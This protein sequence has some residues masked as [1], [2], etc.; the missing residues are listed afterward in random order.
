MRTPITVI[1]HAFPAFICPLQSHAPHTP[2]LP[3]L[4]CLLP[5]RLLCRS[6]GQNSNSAMGT[7]EQSQARA[8]CC[9][10]LPCC[11]G[12]MSLQVGV[13]LVLTLSV[14][15]S[16]ASLVAGAQNELNG[17]D[18]QC[19]EKTSGAVLLADDVYVCGGTIQTLLPASEVSFPALCSCNVGYPHV[20]THTRLVRATLSV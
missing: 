16:A 15:I 20:R 5:S 17:C 13:V 9:A 4:A 12:G 2:S 11:A 7:S 1:M 6:I 10:S 14:F 18:L 8:G 19:T 3:Q